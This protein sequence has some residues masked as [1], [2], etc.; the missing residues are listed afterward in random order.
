MKTT[1]PL[2]IVLSLVTVIGISLGGYTY[3]HRAATEQV[4]AFNCGIVD[5]KPESL[6]QYC[7]DAGV[8]LSNIKW[9]TWNAGGA[10]GTAQYA[11]NNCEPSCVAGT[12]SYA[13]VNVRLSKLA[14]K[15]GKP[16]LSHIYYKTVDGKNLPSGKTAFE[17]WDLV[18]TPL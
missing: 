12:W 7:A 16:V 10:T 15:N 3:V 18:S 4:Y 13:D 11:I 17:E 8:G 2:L 1:R 5:F 6:T 14:H 9:E